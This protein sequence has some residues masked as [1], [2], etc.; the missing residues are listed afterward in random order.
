MPEDPEISVIICQIFAKIVQL[1][2]KEGKTLMGEFYL[3]SLDSH[4]LWLFPYSSI[5]VNNSWYT[6]LFES[7]DDSYIPNAFDLS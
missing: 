7:D 1:S 4:Y 6:Q 5:S 2:K 3:S